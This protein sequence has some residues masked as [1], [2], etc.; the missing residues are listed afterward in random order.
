[1][2]TFIEKKVAVKTASVL[3][4]PE[5]FCERIPLLEWDDFLAEARRIDLQKAEGLIVILAKNPNPNVR[6][7]I[8]GSVETPVS[9]LEKLTE[10][11]ELLVEYKA[12]TTLDHLL[13]RGCSHQ[14]C[15]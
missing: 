1:M 15:G 3:G 11:K 5:D 8:A 7:G 9:I 4:F 2:H 10:D 6:A 14:R 13:Q 12:K